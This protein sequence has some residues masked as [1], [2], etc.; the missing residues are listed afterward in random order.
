[1]AA[2]D[3]AL[4][5]RI[6]REALREARVEADMTQRQVADALEWSLSKIIRIEAA[7][8]SLSVTDLRA[9]LQVYGVQ[10]PATV[11]E[12]EYAARNSKGSSW[13]AEFNDLIK[14]QFAQLLSYEGVAS[15]I[16]IYSPVIISGY[17]HTYD[18]A[19]ALLTERTS[20]EGARRNADLRIKRY[21]RNFESDKGPLIRLNVDEATLVRQIGTPAVMRNQ[22][23]HL[24]EIAANPRVDLTVLP[25]TAG[26]HYSTQHSFTLLS[27][28]GGEN[29]LLYQE[30]AVGLLASSDEIEYIARYRECF[31]DISTRSASGEEAVAL[32]DGALE[33]FAAS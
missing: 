6:L 7:T 32:I 15:E 31:E 1:M 24:K 14:P 16:L 10:D 4:N 13:W 28:S 18:Y 17:V 33:R 22:L 27:F 30:A 23:R 29:D 11:T 25:L 20:E 5:R 19:M 26:A 8:V 21:E 9:M 2:T 12:L 3:P